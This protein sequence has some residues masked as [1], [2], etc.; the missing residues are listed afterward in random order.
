MSEVIHKT[1]DGIPTMINGQNAFYKC[2]TCLK[3]KI[4]RKNTKPEQSELSKIQVNG[5]GQQ[6]HMDYGFVR[7]SD[8][9]QKNEEGKLITSKDDYNAYLLIVDK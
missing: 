3:S 7:G 6:F 9:S 5:P 1:A 8:F 4:E 2:G